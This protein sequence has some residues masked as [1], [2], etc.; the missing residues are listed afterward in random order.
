MFR[1]YRIMEDGEAR[2]LGMRLAASEW[3][4]GKA[5][6]VTGTIKRNSEIVCDLSDEICRR[7]QD[8]VAG[9]QNLVNDTLLCATTLPKF[10]RYRSGDE[11]A[12]HFDAAHMG[13]VRTDY[14]FT[15]ALSEDYEGGRLTVQSRDGLV[16]QAPR[17]PI[18]WCL[19]YPCGGAHWVTPVTK[20][21]RISAIWW[22]E[23]VI[24]DRERRALAVE[25]GSVLAACEATG[26]IEPYGHG[27]TTLTGIHAELL[28]MWS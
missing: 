11:Y 24:A 18:G 6:A 16:V 28:R 9:Q 5:R 12:R 8:L 4:E 14:A 26:S 7:I 27:F 19:A 17:I 21:E 1:T 22:G 2:D 25:M 15:M 20:G 10:N 23:S 13:H 3:S